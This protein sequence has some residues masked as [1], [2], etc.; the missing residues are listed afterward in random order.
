MKH[1]L[2]GGILLAA[3]AVV[4]CG[5]GE[6]DVRSV[7]RS[8]ND[9]NGKRL[10]N[11]YYFHQVVS[12]RREGPKDET[13]FRSFIKSRKPEQLA[14][15]D[16]DPE[17]LDGLFVSER[18]GV[19]FIIRYGVTI[20]GI[21]GGHHQAVVFERQGL[22]GRVEIFMTGPKVADVPHDEMAAYQQGTHDVLNLPPEQPSE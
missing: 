17:R 22:R 4:G 21:G 18:D 15:M 3:L 16:V 13:A 12:P 2:T 9:C 8:N 11:L 1:L 7:V 19:P 14:E 5:S 20:P 10:A 6:L